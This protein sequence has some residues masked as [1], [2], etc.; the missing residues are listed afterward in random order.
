MAVA[1]ADVTF[2]D[3]QQ[4]NVEAAKQVG[5]NAHRVEGI[6]ELRACLLELGFLESDSP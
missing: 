4:A 2:F 3:D 1:A 6:D 5:M